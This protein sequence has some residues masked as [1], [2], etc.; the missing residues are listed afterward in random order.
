MHWIISTVG[1]QTYLKWCV[2]PYVVVVSAWLCVLAEGALRAPNWIRAVTVLGVQIP[3]L[4]AMFV[5][6]VLL[7]RRG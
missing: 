4:I 5:G 7:V 1:N 6:I 3:A 2:L